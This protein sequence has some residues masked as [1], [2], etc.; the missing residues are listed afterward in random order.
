MAEL[1]RP[2]NKRQRVG[3]TGSSSPSSQTDLSMASVLDREK[4]PH[5]LSAVTNANNQ[6]TLRPIRK[7]QSHTS[8]TTMNEE[9]Q[10]PSDKK[11]LSI[12]HKNALNLTIFAPSYHEQLAGVR[13]APINSNFNNMKPIPSQQQLPQQQQQQHRYQYGKNDS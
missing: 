11:R 13:S 12:K 8:N 5:S 1:E 9:Q 4:R 7:I 6:P 3:A 2:S 10:F